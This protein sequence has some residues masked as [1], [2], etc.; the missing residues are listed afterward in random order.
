MG[1][2]L[3]RGSLR[4]LSFCLITEKVFGILGGSFG[5]FL[6][7]FLSLGGFEGPASG[8]WGAGREEWCWGAE[9]PRKAF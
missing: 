2:R 5:S 8:A 9:V 6:N 4:L 3:I 7:L 1:W